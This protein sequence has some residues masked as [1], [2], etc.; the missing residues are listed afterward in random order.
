MHND[1]QDLQTLELLLQ[2]HVC[3]NS[4]EELRADLSTGHDTWQ[5]RQR[6]ADRLRYAAAACILLAILTPAALRA[7]TSGEL[8]CNTRTHTAGM[9]T[10]SE[11][12]LN[13]Q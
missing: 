1:D 2:R 11:Y 5:R 12:F 10:L 7:H 4:V 6:R 8:R 9:V 13:L 3:R